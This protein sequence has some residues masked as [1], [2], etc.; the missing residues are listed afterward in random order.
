MADWK[1]KLAQIAQQNRMDIVKSK[2]SRREMMRLGLLTAGGS[3]VVKAGL[4]ARAFAKNGADDLT[5]AVSVP[6]SPSVRPWLQPMPRLKLKTPVDPYQMTAGLPDA[7][8]KYRIEPPTGYTPV[9]G[10]TQSVPHQYFKKNQDGTYTDT[11]GKTKFYELEMKE[12]SA[13]LHPDYSPTT[14]CLGR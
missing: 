6:P 13:K 1:V 4:S 7:S 10:A 12:V 14:Y 11:F 3:L 5:T 2:L 9:D 8:G